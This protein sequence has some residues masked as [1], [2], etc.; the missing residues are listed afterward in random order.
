MV[1]AGVIHE[2]WIGPS[3]PGYPISMLRLTLVIAVVL[4]LPMLGLVKLFR[5][6]R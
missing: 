1:V 2:V 5:K 3:Q 6:D 4:F